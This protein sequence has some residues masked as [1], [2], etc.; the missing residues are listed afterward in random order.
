[1]SSPKLKW[2]AP[3]PYVCFG[4]NSPRQDGI[5]RTDRPAH[6]RNRRLLI[7]EGRNPVGRVAKSDRV[8]RLANRAERCSVGLQAE[9]LLAGLVILPQLID[10]PLRVQPKRLL[11]LAPRL[12]GKV[13]IE[14]VDR[15]LKTVADLVCLP[16]RVGLK[17]L[18]SRSQE[19]C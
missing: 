3:A 9:V 15:P 16:I 5:I 17:S 10:P 18:G 1:L 8:S 4:G 7:S 2:F 6:H 11:T 19:P 12:G 14:S 13:W